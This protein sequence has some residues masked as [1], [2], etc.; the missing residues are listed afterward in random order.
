MALWFLASVCVAI[1]G[2]FGTYEALGLAG[3]LLCWS[4][5]LALA[6]V[7]GAGTSW[8]MARCCRHRG[9]WQR[10]L[11][12]AAFFTL[13]FLPIL[14]G[15]LLAVTGPAHRH[16]VMDSWQ[17]AGAVL[18]VPLGLSLAE[19]LWLRPRADAGEAAAPG[20]LRPGPRL[21]DRLTPERRGEILHLSGRDH[22]VDVKTDRGKDTLLMRFS[23]AM[24]ELE[25]LDGLQVHRSHW[26]AVE[27]VRGA[28][29]ERGRVY[30][31]LVDGSRVPVSRSHQPEVVERGLL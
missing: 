24:A 30:L 16:L 3:R 2:P 15:V 11:I 14:R 6:F 23:D 8:I 18:M 19:Y 31:T 25:G 17:M 5:I 9:F 7:A 12:D 28:E 1:A 29:R 21:L 20:M 22:Y 13:F 26:V 4:A 10:Q 27:A